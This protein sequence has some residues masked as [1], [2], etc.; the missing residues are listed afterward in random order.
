MNLGEKI[1]T[2]RTEHGWSQSDLGKKASLTKMMVSRYETG[3]GTPPLD[4]LGRIARV[5]GVSVDY[6]VYDDVPRHGQTAVHDVEL[7]ERC[8]QAQ[9]MPEEDRTVVKRVIDALLASHEADRFAAT[10]ATRRSK[11]G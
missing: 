5:L 3:S 8:T 4:K 10:L 11:T 9:T 7:H 6:L 1:R 2:L